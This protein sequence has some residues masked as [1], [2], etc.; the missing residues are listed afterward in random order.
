M[1]QRYQSVAGIFG[2]IYQ[3]GV[4]QRFVEGQEEDEGVAYFDFEEGNETAVDYLRTNV[5]YREKIDSSFVESETISADTAEEAGEVELEE[6]LE[7]QTI[8]AIQVE[9][10]FTVQE[11]NGLFELKQYPAVLELLNAVREINLTDDEILV[12]DQKV[13]EIM[14]AT[15]MWEESGVRLGT[16]EDSVMIE[17]DNVTEVFRVTPEA[18]HQIIFTMTTTDWMSVKAPIP[19]VE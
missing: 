5:I 11:G 7:P 6:V 2:R 19:V 3:V 9:F 12:I 1:L 13:Q 18:P 8:E 17:R 15:M 4:G 14:M 16:T 10:G